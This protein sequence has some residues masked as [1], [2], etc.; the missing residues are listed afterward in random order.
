[1]PHTTIVC[2]VKSDVYYTEAAVNQTIHMCTIRSTF[3]HTFY[4]LYNN[5]ILYVMT[6]LVTVVLIKFYNAL[7]DSK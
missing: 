1:M 2:H 4:I 6:Y 7:I 5:Y 3:F